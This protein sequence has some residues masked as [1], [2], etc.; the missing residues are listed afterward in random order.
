MLGEYLTAEGFRIQCCHSGSE[1]LESI[2]NLSPDLVVLDVMLPGIG[3]LQLLPLIR[4]KSRLPVIMLTARGDRTDRIIGLELGADDY[5]PKPFDPR[6]LLARIRSVLRRT[7]PQEP[8]E[9]FRVAGLRLHPKRRSATLDGHVLPLT[10]LEFDLLALLSQNAGT[11][12]TRDAMADAI[13]RRLLSFDRSIDM[14]VVNLRRKLKVGDRPS[15][16]ILTVRGTGYLLAETE[17]R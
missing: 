5:L 12:V 7:Q 17:D 3:G 6:E 1:V 15:L 2:S 14:H 13:G 4:S 10:S 9:E 11:V 16:Q 8:S